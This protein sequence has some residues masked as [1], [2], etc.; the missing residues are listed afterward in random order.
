MFLVETNTCSSPRQIHSISR[1]RRRRRI[2]YHSQLFNR[3]RDLRWR[4]VA[5]KALVTASD[6]SLHKVLRNAPRFPAAGFYTLD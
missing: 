1:R 4:L 3:T 2:R 5:G 6:M